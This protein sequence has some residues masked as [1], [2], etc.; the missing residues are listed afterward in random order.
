MF[1]TDSIYIIGH[2]HKVCED[3]AYAGI[4]SNEISNIPYAIIC[5]GCSSEKDSD[6]GARLLAH[7]F[8]NFL[9]KLGKNIEYYSFNFHDLY[10]D[11]CYHIKKTIHNSAENVGLHPSSFVATIRAMAVI[12]DK[13]FCF[14]FGDGYTIH[15]HIKN[16]KYNFIATT[17]FISNAP[18]YFKH[19]IDTKERELYCKNYINYDIIHNG[20]IINDP[21]YYINSN[22]HFYNVISLNELSKG[23]HIFTVTSDGIDTFYTF[24]ENEKQINIPVEIIMDRAFAF[25]NFQ[26]KFIQRRFNRFFKDMQKENIKHYD[27]FSIASIHYNKS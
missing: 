11:L 15:Q 10:S 1:N 2:N 25:K 14:H 22:N 19:H 6:I 18:Y 5:D 23:N 16:N 27:D 17:N 12:K 9:R 26:G 4:I 20:Y 3:Y 8:K 24:D 21:E 7:G 13:L